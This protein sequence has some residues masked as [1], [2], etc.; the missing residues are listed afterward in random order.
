MLRASLPQEL[1]LMVIEHDLKVV[2][3]LTDHVFVFQQGALFEQGSPA[4]IRAS[5]RVQSIYFKGRQHA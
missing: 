1:T 5:E 4:E 3:G 2:E